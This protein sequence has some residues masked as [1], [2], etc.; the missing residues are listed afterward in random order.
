MSYAKFRITH[1]EDDLAYMLRFSHEYFDVSLH[2]ISYY[3]DLIC[4]V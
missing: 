1:K 2:N 3:L 4:C